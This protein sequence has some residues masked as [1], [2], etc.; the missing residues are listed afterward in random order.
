MP[1]TPSQ[2]QID[3]SRNHCSF[4]KDG[5]GDSDSNS[6]FH[7]NDGPLASSKDIIHYYFQLLLNGK[8][9]MTKR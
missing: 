4:D 6:L 9:S 2:F 1:D 7:N 8:G 3:I 5:G